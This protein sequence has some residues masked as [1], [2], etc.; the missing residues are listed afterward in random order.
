[1]DEI[2]TKVKDQL[3]SFKA[4]P[5]AKR[6]V[7]KKSKPLAIDSAAIDS[8][9]IIPK[10]RDSKSQQTAD[11]RSIGTFGTS[12]REVFPLKPSTA[13]FISVEYPKRIPGGF[14]SKLGKKPPEAKSGPVQPITPNYSINKKKPSSAIIN[15]KPFKA[16]SK[17][18]VKVKAKQYEIDE[19]SQGS[20]LNFL[21]LGF[22]Q[23]MHSVST[24]DSE[25]GDFF[26]AKEKWEQQLSMEIASNPDLNKIVFPASNALYSRKPKG[27]S[28]GKSKAK[29]EE[30][31]SPGP[32]TYLPRFETVEKTPKGV[33]FGKGPRMPEERPKEELPLFPNYDFVLKNPPAFKYANESEK[34]EQLVMKEEEEDEREA[35]RS[36]LYK[37]RDLEIPESQRAR[38]T[39]GVISPYVEVPTRYNW[40]RLGP[41]K[42]DPNYSS[43]EPQVLGNVGYAEPNFEFKV[44]RFIN[45]GPGMYYIVDDEDIPGGYIPGSPRSRSPISDIRP[46]L[47]PDY[48][49]SKPHVPSALIL[50]EGF[51]KPTE[52]DALGPGKYTP[53][54]KLTEKRSDLDVLP[55][56]PE[57]A[58]E[59]ERD[60][61]LPLF[62]NESLV[63]PG[64]PSVVFKPPAEVA[65]PHLPDSYFAPEQWKFYDVDGDLKFDRPS[66]FSF[67]PTD[68]E[69]FRDYEEDKKVLARINQRLRGELDMPT[70]GSYDPEPV[71]ARAPAYE[72]GKATS[73]DPE[74][75][76]DL[77]DEDREGD[78]LVLNPHKPPKVPVLVNMDKSTGRDE[79]QDETEYKSELIIQ[80]NYEAIKKRVSVLVNM[81]KA[82]GRFDRLERIEEE[83]EKLILS[84]NYD[85]GRKKVP[86]LVN[87]E[88]Q[89]PRE[90]AHFE[91]IDHSDLVHVEEPKA[92]S[93]PPRS[94]VNMHKMT[95]RHEEDPFEDELVVVQLPE[96]PEKAPKKLAI[97]DFSKM[98]GRHEVKEP[99]LECE[100]ATDQKALVSP[101]DLYR[102][103]EP[104]A[105][106]PSFERFVGR[107]ETIT[108]DPSEIPFLVKT[109]YY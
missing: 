25:F 79:A 94:V 16:E 42:Y 26:R 40:E 47:S 6:P 63:K 87:I 3:E 68:Y 33:K 34:T 58:K 69:S 28:E 13:D 23:A 19:I 12:K 85:V 99:E 102:A 75:L 104:S 2:F 52:S 15:P 92:A 37:M 107:S 8:A 81:D 88:K 100:V 103:V 9:D 89:L 72:F 101:D 98:T 109:G 61:R 57:K 39:G 7:A 97:P 73:R 21:H 65:P 71:T 20:E 80:P 105:K 38:V 43:V 106:A 31:K 54:Y 70:V 17:S 44:P 48:N 30:E 53:S 67:A 82:L 56:I 4:K 29:A 96:L 35:L 86:V 22:D 41:G 83:E 51:A 50:P 76:Q 14:I 108:E 49:F 27:Q 64:I 36:I 1:M 10:A 59:E 5:K 84:P 77:Q 24:A 91:E 78:V 18:P 11:K 55:F 93:K 95:G 74:Y 46:A 62:I 90:P 45:P 32:H 66:E 60:D